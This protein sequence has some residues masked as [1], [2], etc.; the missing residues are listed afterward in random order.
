MKFGEHL[1]DDKL[2]NVAGG[3]MDGVCNDTTPAENFENKGTKQTICPY[4]GG[5]AADDGMR[6]TK[7]GKS[8]YNAQKCLGCGKVWLY[9][10]PL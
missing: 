7:D 4:C 6:G 1:K 10:G 2:G 9:G 5:T 8:Y 3:V